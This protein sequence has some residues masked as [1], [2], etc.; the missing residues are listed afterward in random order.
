V[1]GSIEWQ[2]RIE[3]WYGNTLLFLSSWVRNM[4]WNWWEI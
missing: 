1:F 3:R 2:M 4:L